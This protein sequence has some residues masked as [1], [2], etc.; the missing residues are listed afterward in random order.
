M[1]AVLAVVIVGLVCIAGVF[2]YLLGQS[3]DDVSVEDGCPERVMTP[4]SGD[5]YIDM[6]PP[7]LAALHEAMPIQRASDTVSHAD[8]WYTIGSLLMDND[9]T[10]FCVDYETPEA[11]ELVDEPG[12]HFTVRCIGR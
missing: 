10:M 3:D 7:A 8:G 1:R 6:C 11:M 9:G 4:I 5:T 2:G 12:P